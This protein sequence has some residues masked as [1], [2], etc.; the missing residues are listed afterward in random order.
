MDFSAPSTTLIHQACETPG[1]FVSRTF[2]KI[3]LAGLRVGA[4]VGARDAIAELDKVRLPWNLDALAGAFAQIVLTH[5]SE[6]EGRIAALVRLRNSFIDRLRAVPGVIAFPSADSDRAGPGARRPRHRV[7]QRTLPRCAASLAL[8]PPRACS[9]RSA[10]KIT[11]LVAGGTAHPDRREFTLGRSG[12][13]RT[14]Q[15]DLVAGPDTFG[16][17]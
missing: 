11:F 9:M 13:R 14:R 8:S 12:G 7:R 16:A 1:L 17:S 2:S 10:R 15:L 5:A 6:L 3:G 4:L